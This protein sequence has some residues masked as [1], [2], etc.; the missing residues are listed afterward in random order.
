MPVYL[1]MFFGQSG[2]VNP[3]Q[4]FESIVLVLVVPFVLA[5]AT[6]L[7][8]HRMNKSDLVK[9][10]LLPFFEL[11]QVIF[12]G[13]AILAMF[14][15][16]GNYLTSNVK[17]VY[18]LL[19][20]LLIFFIGN[21]FVSRFA[22]YLLNFNYQDSASLNL[23]TLARNSPISLAIAIT[24]FPNDPLIALALVIGPLI[25]LPVLSVVSNLLLKVRRWSLVE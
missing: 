4:L 17:V 20:P 14:A 18:I 5:Q 25:E 7:L 19:V 10:R 2:T 3:G 21:F 13:L 12:L 23:T 11:T 16:Q 6:K 15:S 9:H 24:A 1:L 8:S 22:S